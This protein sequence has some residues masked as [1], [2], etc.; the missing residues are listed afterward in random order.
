MDVRFFIGTKSLHR[1]RVLWALTQAAGTTTGYKGVGWKSVFRVTDEPHVSL[2]HNWRVRGGTGHMNI[3]F[4]QTM[5]SGIPTSLCL[6]IR[7]Q[8]AHVH[9]VFGPLRVES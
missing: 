5:F 2:P 7:M 3:S 9:V 1:I 6:S 4:L 8:D